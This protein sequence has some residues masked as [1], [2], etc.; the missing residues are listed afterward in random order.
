MGQYFF[1][2]HSQQDLI[3]LRRFTQETW[4]EKQ[5]VVYL[6]NLQDTLQLLSSMPSMGKNCFDDL[7]ENIF[8]FPSGAHMI[9]YLTQPAEEVVVIAIFHQSMVPTKHLGSRL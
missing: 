3:Q 7:G 1:T 2:K 5:S 6:Q 4:G 9:Y 8:R